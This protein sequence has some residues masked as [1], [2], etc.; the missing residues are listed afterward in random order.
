[1]RNVSGSLVN[2]TRR[3]I[4]IT[5]SVWKF[6]QCLIS[7]SIKIDFLVTLIPSKY[8]SIKCKELR[9]NISVIKRQFLNQETTYM[10]NEVLSYM[11]NVPSTSFHFSEKVLLVELADLLYVPEDNITLS[12]ENLWHIFP[13]KFRDVVIDNEAEWTDIVSFRLDHLPCYEWQCPVNTDVG[14]CQL[15]SGGKQLLNSTEWVHFKNRTY[16]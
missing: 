2:D 1:M 10:H 9:E 7:I 3:T 12:S 13:L 11:E 16:E 8:H 15:P 5:I 6:D 4:S 14:L